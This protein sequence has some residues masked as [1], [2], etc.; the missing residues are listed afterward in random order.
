LLTVKVGTWNFDKF[1]LRET[2]SRQ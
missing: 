1:P 2:I